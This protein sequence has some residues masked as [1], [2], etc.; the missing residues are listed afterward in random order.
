MSESSTRIL[1]SHVGSL[2]RPA[3]LRSIM[4]ARAQGAAYDEAALGRELKTAV[5]DVVT[6]QGELGLDIISD[7]E[8][9]KAGWNR[10]VVERMEGF[11]QRPLN[12][13][14]KPGSNFDLSGEARAFPGFYAAYKVLQEFDW[15]EG[16]LPA[17][18]HDPDVQQKRMVWECVGPIRYKAN[19]AQRDIANFKAALDATEGATGFMPAASPLS[20]RGLWG[21][22]FYKSDDEI[23]VALAEALRHEYRAIV[24][25]GL[26]LQVDDP[27]LV[28]NYPRLASDV[29]DVQTRHFLEG[30]V[31]L[32][33][34]AL[35]GI[36][37][38]KIRYH[39]C[40]GSW[41]GPHTFD[42]PLAKVLPLVLKV[43]AGAYS[44]E[45]ANPRHEHEW[46]VWK[47]VRL[48]AGK[49]LMPGV[50]SHCTNVVEHPELVAMRLVNFAKVVGRDNI[51]AG[52]DCGF[53]QSH[54]HMRVHSSIQWA[55]LKSVVEGA[56][57]ASAALW[58]R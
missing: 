29:G 5:A 27:Y 56:R 33:N 3:A 42:F 58:R 2:V 57:L 14:E 41:N 34:H 45:A 11:V 24:D 12:P 36:P 20:A 22:S 23:T 37:E 49:M 16:R 43:R 9:G 32:L 39:V 54:D 48:P 28:D 46:T 40:W 19:A 26:L 31:E 38:E 47:D 8:F 13:G 53:S 6:K 1:T 44:L 21:S 55:K 51:V 25:A 17:T 4:T 10:Y 15:E 30:R 7:G 52:T 50:V 35:D 18:R